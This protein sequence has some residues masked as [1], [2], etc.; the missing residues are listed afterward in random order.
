MLEISVA[1]GAYQDII[2]AGGVFIENGYNGS[3]GAGTNNPL[4]NRNAWTGQS[5]GYITS[6]VRLPPSGAIASL[7]LMHRLSRAFSS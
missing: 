2:T 1:G 7:A 4:A 3:L 6:I 5:D